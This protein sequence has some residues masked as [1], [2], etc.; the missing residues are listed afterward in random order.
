MTASCS[1]TP[2][3]KTV[4]NFRPSKNS[5]EKAIER[6]RIRDL[7]GELEDSEQSNSSETLPENL[8]K[9]QQ[10]KGISLAIGSK[11]LSAGQECTCPVDEM[12]G[13]FHSRLRV[14]NTYIHN[15]GKAVGLYKY[16]HRMQ[17]SRQYNLFNLSPSL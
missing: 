11:P 7:I 6:T 4:H 13:S 2:V 14:L 1:L 8:N 15:R 16:N 3:Q 12:F 17:P 9:A 5:S 10:C